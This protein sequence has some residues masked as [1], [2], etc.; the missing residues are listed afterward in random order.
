[1]RRLLFAV[2]LLTLVVAGCRIETNIGIALEADG[3]GTASI[4]IGMD[5]EALVFIEAGGQSFEDACSTE[6]IGDLIGENPLEDVISAEAGANAEVVEEDGLTVCRTSFG[7]DD[8]TQVLDTAGEDGLA[9]DV[10]ISDDEVRVTGVL[11]GTGGDEG[12]LGDLGFDP[13]LLEDAFAVNLRIDMPGS[14]IESNADRTLGDGTLEWNVDLFGGADTVIEAVSD[15]SGSDGGGGV[16]TIVIVVLLLAVVGAVL[17]LYLRNRKTPLGADV[18]DP[19][20]D[21][22]AAPAPP[23][24]PAAVDTAEAADGPEGTEI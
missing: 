13:S 10:A 24:P 1:M 12:D 9:L 2:V 23:E 22:V 21:P 4:D 19:V 6:G 16:A 17:F 8:V 15:P 18:V 3:S 7:F 5:D 20:A 14:V 11:A